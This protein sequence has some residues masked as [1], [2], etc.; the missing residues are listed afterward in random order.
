MSNINSSCP[1]VSTTR[2][3]R[4]ALGCSVG[5]VM[6][7]GGWTGR[8]TLRFTSIFCSAFSSV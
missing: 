4:Q 2:V 7:G 1:K 6:R 5:A 8:S 3:G